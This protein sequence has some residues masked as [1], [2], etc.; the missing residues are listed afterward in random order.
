LNER[1][2]THKH[3]REDRGIYK[4]EK[5]ERREREEGSK[6]R[7]RGKKERERRVNENDYKY[8]VLTFL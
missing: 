5:R 4:R 8:R 1:E 2:K 3:K 6:G 7:K